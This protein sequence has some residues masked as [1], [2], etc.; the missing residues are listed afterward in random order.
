MV[1][2]RIC[3]ATAVGGALAYPYLL[4]LHSQGWPLALALALLTPLLAVWAA[5]R[6]NDAPG[7]RRL[8]LFTA[9]A[10]PVFTA[11][12]VLLYMAGSDLPD[13][14]V[15]GGIWLLAGLLALLARRSA[16][17][18]VPAV[19]A[20]AWRVVHGVSALCVILLFLGMHLLNHVAGLWGEAA[21]RALME[22]FRQVYRQPLTEPLVVALFVVQIISGLRLAWGWTERPMDG[23]RL[24]Q[25]ATGVYLVFF[26]A[27]HMNSVFFYARSFAGIPTDW[28]FATGAP[29]GLLRDAWNVRLIAHYFYGVFGVIAHAVLGA[30]GLALAHGVQRRKADRWTRLGIASSAGVAALILLGMLRA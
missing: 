17:R 24:L 3:L 10:P 16:E 26:I 13:H 22:A 29:K 21:H 20:R 14:L 19:P 1:S 8:A 7:W 18:A 12:G 5:H 11:A 2:K 30:R 15:T 9:A 6:I 23:W 28:A 27:G 25:V 4:M